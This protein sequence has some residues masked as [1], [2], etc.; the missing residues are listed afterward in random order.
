[1]DDPGLGPSVEAAVPAASD[2]LWD[3]WDPPLRAP[4]TPV[5]HLAG[6]DGPMALLLD[7]A[8]RQRIDLGRL[9][10]AELAAQFVAE[11]EG[12]LRAMPLEQRADWLVMAARLLLLRSRLLFPADA[13]AAVAAERDARAELDRLEGAMLARAA[14]SWLGKRPYLG[15]DVFARPRRGPDPRVASYMAL[16]EA[17]LVV[18]RGRSWRE[19]EVPVYRPVLPELWRV[20]DA[21][22]R[23]RW[24][25]AE[26]PAGGAFSL[27]LPPVAEG[28]LRALQARAAVASSF[29]AA[30]ELC[31]SGEVAIIQEGSF[32]AIAIGPGA[33]PEG[34]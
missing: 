7:L 25:L 27:F 2:P 18:L 10:I 28:P 14:A 5:L 16:M 6:F 26:S 31:R 3:D 12:R 15:L 24:L 19:A 13:T 1:M 22:A 33:F 21:L 34:T 4:E 17:C 32:E 9:A 29:V 8:E 20:R 23:I 30:L 11:C